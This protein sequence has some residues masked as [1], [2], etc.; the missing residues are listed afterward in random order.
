[1]SSIDINWTNRS[2][3]I[4]PPPD[5]N[6]V[7]RVEQARFDDDGDTDSVQIL[8]QGSG[9]DLSVSIPTGS[10]TDNTLE[11][12]R[13]YSYRVVAQRDETRKPSLFTEYI[14]TYDPAMELG[15]P[16]GTPEEAAYMC[17]VVPH[18]H[19]DMQKIGGY[20]TSYDDGMLS[21]RGSTRIGDVYP[22][23]GENSTSEDNVYL[24]E[25]TLAEIGKRAS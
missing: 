11:S 1:M 21:M 15:Y 3:S 12:N 6:I 13:N 19:V 8:A 17:S 14:H 16:G 18:V 7:E 24:D 4:Q 23:R 2:A 10:Y 5:K 25:Q 9:G 20:S 22:I